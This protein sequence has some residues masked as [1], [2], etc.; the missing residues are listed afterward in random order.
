MET[1][2]IVN[3]VSDAIDGAATGGYLA[4]ALVGT[5]ATITVICGIVWFLLVAIAR[6]KIFSKAGKKG[7]LSII[8]VVSQWNEVDLSWNST[9]AW[10][11]IALLVAGSI[12]SGIQNGRAENPSTFIAVLSTVFGLAAAVIKIISQWKLSKAFG[13]GIG[14]FIGLLLLNPIFMIILGFG[15]AQYQGRPG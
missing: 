4:G 14:F 10:I 5:M 1:D 8:P 6:W 11:S 13:K 15:S 12:F 7:W 2:I 9:W 3:E